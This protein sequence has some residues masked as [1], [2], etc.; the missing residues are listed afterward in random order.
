[1]DTINKT[2]TF[3][4]VRLDNSLS[5]DL[6]S[7]ACSISKGKSNIRVIPAENI[8]LTLKFIGDVESKDIEIIKALLE[9][10]AKKNKAFKSSLE[11]TIDAFPGMKKA[12]VIL[13]KVF[14]GSRE[15]V[16]IFKDIEK[17][18]SSIGVKKETRGFIPHI[19]IARSRKP[20]DLVFLKGKSLFDKY[21]EIDVSNITLFKST[22]KNTGAEYSIIECF[23]LK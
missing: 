23:D 10:I 2:R 13:F 12:K 20:S 4:A 7:I 3:I 17:G 5:A 15:I 16:D 18:L 21:P 19:T 8:H 6:H 14:K 1:M 9:D 22:L 11:K